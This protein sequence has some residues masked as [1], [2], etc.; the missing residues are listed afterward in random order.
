MANIFSQVGGLNPARSVFSL[1]HTVKFDADMG[2]LYP[3]FC[4]DAVPGD[5]F[6]I[7][8]QCVIRFHQPL[9]APLLHEVNAFV[10]VY[11]VPYRIL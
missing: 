5:V 6:D 3:I 8:V 4:E 11:F 2:K 9:F 1:N 10:H 7:A